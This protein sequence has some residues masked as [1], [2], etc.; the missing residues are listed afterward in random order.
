MPRITKYDRIISR[1]FATHDDSGASVA[2]EKHYRLV[3]A[4]EI[5]DELIRRYSIRPED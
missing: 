5:P 3:P 2:A 4:E 1:V